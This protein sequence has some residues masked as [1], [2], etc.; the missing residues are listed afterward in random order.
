MKTTPASARP[1]QYPHKPQ[2]STSKPSSARASNT[3]HQLLV[4]E[5]QQRKKSSRA[6]SVA[7]SVGA[8]FADKGPGIQEIKTHLRVD[9]S[10]SDRT[11]HLLIK[12]LYP[13][14]NETEQEEK[15]HVLG[16]TGYGL[17]I[18]LAATQ[19][20]AGALMTYVPP[21]GEYFVTEPEFFSGAE[22]LKVF[23]QGSFVAS[24]FV[25]YGELV[26]VGHNKLEASP[27][28]K[29]KVNAFYEANT[30]KLTAIL[31]DTTISVNEKAYDR[32]CKNFPRVKIFEESVQESANFKK[33][34]MFL[35]FASATFTLKMAAEDERFTNRKEP[36]QHESFMIFM[37]TLLSAG[38][39]FALRYCLPKVDAIPPPLDFS[40]L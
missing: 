35:F 36:Y 31:N 28:F 24:L 22:A 6:S 34:I 10:M 27:A 1:S 4:T 21:I 2:A 7:S 9:E 26:R 16:F 14:I 17:P 5:N 38:L 37:N 39:S 19:A 30:D 13:L 18:M 23:A 25:L 12:N 8:I 32:I 11:R 29:A 15:K 20:T 33:I 3:P 40:A